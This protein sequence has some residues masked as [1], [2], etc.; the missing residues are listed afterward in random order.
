MQSIVICFEYSL[1]TRAI[2]KVFIAASMGF[3]LSNEDFVRLNAVDEAAKKLFLF[4][5]FQKY[6]PFF[7]REE[8]SFKQFCRQL[9]FLTS[10]G[11]EGFL[12]HRASP[13]AINL[14]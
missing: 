6:V 14:D 2:T 7:N 11:V 5:V 10:H 4:V 3:Y 9:E 1:S 12:A 13:Y 8:G